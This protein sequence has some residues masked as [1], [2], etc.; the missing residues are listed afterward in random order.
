MVWWFGGLVVWWFGGLVVW[1]FGAFVVSWF[2]VD[3][4]NC[5]QFS[6]VQFPKPRI[7]TA[8]QPNSQTT[9]HHQ[10]NQP[11][12]QTNNQPTGHAKPANTKTNHAKRN[13]KDCIST[14]P[15]Q[16]QKRRRK[17]DISPRPAGQLMELNTPRYPKPTNPAAAREAPIN[18]T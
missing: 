5:L 4:T 18:N 3:V 17:L 13:N 11:N 12:N 14:Q 10:P 6:G 15:E 8:K 16:Q 9:N 1:W 2:G 7:Q